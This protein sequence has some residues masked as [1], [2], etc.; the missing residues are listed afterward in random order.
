MGNENIFCQL[1]NFSH[2]NKIMPSRDFAEGNKRC[3]ELFD[4]GEEK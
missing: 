4:K 3:S 2:T 1:G